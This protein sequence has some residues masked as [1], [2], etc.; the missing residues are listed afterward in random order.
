MS[1]CI[2]GNKMAVCL[3]SL[4]F[5]G[6]P[7]KFHWPVRFQSNLSPD[8]TE[9]SM[10]IQMLKLLVEKLQVVLNYLAH[11]AYHVIGFFLDFFR[12]ALVVHCTVRKF[13]PSRFPLVRDIVFTA[14]GMQ[15]ILKCANNIQS[16]DAYRII[17]V[18]KLLCF[19]FRNIPSFHYQTHVVSC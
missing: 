5:A 9:R 6:F 18:P 19:F 8:A 15:I 16:H 2:P 7:V 12:L 14:I 11:K 13:D 1:T 10:S 4:I 17:Q 3:P